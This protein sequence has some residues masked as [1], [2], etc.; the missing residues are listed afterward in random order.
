MSGVEPESDVG[1]G[2][3]EEHSEIWGHTQL[4]RDEFESRPCSDVP[5]LV[6]LVVYACALS[7]LSVVAAALSTPSWLRAGW[8][9]HGRICGVDPSQANLS[10]V[11]WPR[12]EELRLGRC[13]LEC[14][15]GDEA[16]AEGV[17]LPRPQPVIVSS[18][19]FGADLNKSFSQSIRWQSHRAYPT[20]PALGRFCLPPP[21]TV[22][23]LPPPGIAGAD[24]STAGGAA[25]PGGYGADPLSAGMPKARDSML[26]SL[27]AALGTPDAQLRRAIGGLRFFR[28]GLAGSVLLVPLLGALLVLFAARGEVTCAAAPVLLGTGALG[29]SA[30]LLRSTFREDDV[31]I[32][33]LSDLEPLCARVACWCLGATG[34]VTLAATIPLAPQLRWAA[35]CLDAT[36]KVLI[37]DGLALPLGFVAAAIAIIQALACFAWLVLLEAAVSAAVIRWPG[38]PPA[39][40]LGRSKHSLPDAAAALTP[41]G[42]L[43]RSIIRWPSFRW[44]ALLVLVISGLL[45]RGVLALLLALG[46]SLVAHVVAEWY[47]GSRGGACL[48]AAAWATASAHLGGAAAAAALQ[49]LPGA[50]LLRAASAALHSRLA[51]RAR[52]RGAFGALAVALGA[53]P[54][55]E[56]A[57]FAVGF[58]AGARRSARALAG[59]LPAAQYLAGLPSLLEAVACGLA[60]LLT[61]TLWLLQLGGR[62][63][64]D[65]TH[66]EL[67]I[68]VAAAAAALAVPLTSAWLLPLSAGF[69]ALLECAL[70]DDHIEPCDSVAAAPVGRWAF[71]ADASHALWSSSRTPGPMRRLLFEAAQ[72]VQQDAAQQ[73]Q[74][75]THSLVFSSIGASLRRSGSVASAGY[76]PVGIGGPEGP[77]SDDD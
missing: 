47:F 38:E 50:L 73:A 1:A 41:G 6:G 14:P 16:L 7:A 49:G 75:S 54:A 24:S 23:G 2:A 63:H 20:L 35:S 39:A 74:R 8:D 76:A 26:P 70:L 28:A 67:P 31:A 43:V 77:E 30:W 3:G 5:C 18:S 25:P 37:N 22:L 34:L 29:L 36:A 32:A 15:G 48:G 10:F 66:L 71:G 59:A 62:G 51:P 12:P 57:L 72:R 4:D 46:R 33:T 40:G 60:G 61:G 56:A 42:P 55:A 9:F 45:L 17:W 69:D 44:D 58:G 52:G 11:F 13:V 65:P 53:A 68:G 64:E 19:G 27:R 21:D